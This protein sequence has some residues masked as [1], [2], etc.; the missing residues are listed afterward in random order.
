LS[1]PQRD[2]ADAK[3]ATQQ[4]Q[5]ASLIALLTVQNPKLEDTPRKRQTV[6]EGRNAGV[7]VTEAFK[8]WTKP[9]MTYPRP[10][11]REAAWMKL[12]VADADDNIGPSPRT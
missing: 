2:A 9:P 10:A 4:G 7:T 6:Q 11:D 1:T 12:I 5:I 3:A 8:L